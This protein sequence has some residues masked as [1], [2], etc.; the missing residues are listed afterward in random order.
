LGANTGGVATFSFHDANPQSG[1]VVLGDIRA[2]V[3][4]AAAG[5]YKAT[6]LLTIGAITINGNGASGAVSA[7]GVHVNVYL[8]DVTGNGAIDGADTLVANSVATGAASGFGAYPRIDPVL[9][10]DPKSDNSVD[11]L[12]V[13]TIDSFVALLAPKEIPAPPGGLSFVSPNRVGAMVIGG[14]AVDG[15]R[16]TSVPPYHYR[17][18]YEPP[19]PQA[20]RIPAVIRA[21]RQEW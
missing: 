14:Q 11:G 12:D 16:S 6:Q 10:G 18:L 1:T 5:S 21:L 20:R 9:A 13:S 4:S 2:T 17:H 19:R 8:G 7:N 3:P 15:S